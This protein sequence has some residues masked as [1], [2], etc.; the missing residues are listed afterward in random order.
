MAKDKRALRMECWSSLRA[1]R[2]AR[3]PGAVGRIP[4]FTGAEAAAE[5]LTR[6]RVWERARVIKANPDLP[7]RP[8]RYAALKAGKRVYMAVPRLRDRKAFLL[9]DPARLGE[10]ALWEASSI[11]GAFELGRPVAFHELD[12]IDLIVTGCVGVS[13]DGARLGKGG[14]FSDLEYAFLREAT[15]A[16]A[17]TPIVTT[18]H[19]TQVLRKGRIPMAPHDVSVDLFATPEKLVR[20]PR[21]HRRPRGI[22]WNLLDDAKRAEIPLLADVVPPPKRKRVSARSG[23]R[24]RGRGPRSRRNPA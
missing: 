22:L 3:F 17:R 23:S 15:H 13:S 16:T 21:A 24:R 1:V 20:C 7:Q 18:V 2:A 5:R 12:H 6:E 14:G 11:Q 10:K 8:L 4:N 9:L 19:P